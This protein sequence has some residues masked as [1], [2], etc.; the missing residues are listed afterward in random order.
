[1]ASTGS[2]PPS[3]AKRKDLPCQ[4]YAGSQQE[5]MRHGAFANLKR[6][7]AYSHDDRQRILERLLQDPDVSQRSDRAL[8]RDLGMSHV[9][10]G[11]AAHRLAAEATLA[12]QWQAVP[13][14]QTKEEARRQEQIAA[15]LDVEPA[16]VAKY[17]K[18][19]TPLDKDRIIPWV[20]RRMT[21]SSEPE[22]Q[23]KA[24]VRAHLQK[25]VREREQERAWRRKHRT[26]KPT[27]AEEAAREADRERRERENYL[28]DR[29][30]AFVG[31]RDGRQYLFKLEKGYTLL[32]MVEALS[33]DSVQALPELLNQAEAVI[34][35]LRDALAGSRARATEA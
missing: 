28:M 16:V 12:A 35:T 15:F 3:C 11:R 27:P 10:V 18:I 2:K 20:A 5:A 23:A 1:M 21:D 34:Q 9:T 4:V 29:T 26:P 33:P 19:I 31:V 7:L 6:G 13:V 8:A 17:D 25:V 14:T 32:D 24:G 22:A 30:K